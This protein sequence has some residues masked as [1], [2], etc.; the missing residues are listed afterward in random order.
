M[1]VRAHVPARRERLPGCGRRSGAGPPERGRIVVERAGDPDDLTV[2]IETAA[3]PGTAD[4]ARP[5]WPRR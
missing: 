4:A 2:E 5:T 3:D 1:P